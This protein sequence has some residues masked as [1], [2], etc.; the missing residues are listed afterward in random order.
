MFFKNLIEED[1]KESRISWE[2]TTVEP[3]AD[4]SERHWCL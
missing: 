4:N 3:I 2:E 1:N